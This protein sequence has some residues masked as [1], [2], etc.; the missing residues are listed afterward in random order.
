M[1]NTFLYHYLNNTN[2][3]MYITTR[4]LILAINIYK[5][6]EKVG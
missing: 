1:N 4:M 5:T 3:T 6:F 2:K